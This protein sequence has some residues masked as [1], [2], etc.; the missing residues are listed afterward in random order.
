MTQH[1][2]ALAI[3]LLLALPLS[4]RAQEPVLPSVPQSLSLDQAVEL[5]VR[6]NPA[7][8]QTVN[9]RGPAAWGVRNAYGE[10]LP[11]LSASGGLG[12]A[13]P[14]SQTFLS[15]QFTQP[16]STIGS[17][18]SLGLSWQLSGSTLMPTARK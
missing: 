15:Q 10:F 18:Y 1:I 17:S 13:G 4:A 8:R 7:Y 2:S 5:A 6:N 16:S 14:G 11:A 12:Y 9:D 3:G